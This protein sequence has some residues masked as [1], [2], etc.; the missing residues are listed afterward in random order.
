MKQQGCVTSKTVF[1]LVPNLK[2]VHGAT[3]ECSSQ[4]KGLNK[5]RKRPVA[6]KNN[7]KKKKLTNPGFELGS[8]RLECGC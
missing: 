7:R 4:K 5:K 1:L 6:S 8:T 2:Q 3:C